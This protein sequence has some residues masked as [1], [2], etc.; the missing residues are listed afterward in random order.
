MP[1]TVVVLALRPVDADIFPAVM[2]YWR[3]CC[4]TF[5]LTQSSYDVPAVVDVVVMSPPVNDDV[6]FILHLATPLVGLSPVVFVA[7]DFTE[8][9]CCRWLFSSRCF[10]RKDDD[11]DADVDDGED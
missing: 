4:R 8:N 5:L 1:A 11:V 2:S 10:F 3:W 7:A 9:S 6:I